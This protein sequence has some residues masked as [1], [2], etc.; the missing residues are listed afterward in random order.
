M[1]I[2]HLCFFFIRPLNNEFLLH[3]SLWYNFF[4]YGQTKNHNKET[5]QLS[6]TLGSESLTDSIY[7]T[8]KKNSLITNISLS[9]PAW[10]MAHVPPL[11]W[12]IYIY[13][14]IYIYIKEKGI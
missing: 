11:I 4:P 6:A 9:V 13:I 12:N 1:G 14:Y 7:F 3:S 10:P 2:M 5:S 8:C